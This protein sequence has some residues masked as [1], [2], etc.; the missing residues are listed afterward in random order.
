MIEAIIEA[1][2]DAKIDVTT[3]PMTEAITE[4]IIHSGKDMN[5]ATKKVNVRSSRHDVSTFSLLI[6]L[7]STP[8]SIMFPSTTSTQELQ[9]TLIELY[10]ARQHARPFGCQ[11]RSHDPFS[12]RVGTHKDDVPPS[13]SYPK[14]T[15]L[16]H[17]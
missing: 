5:I 3:D 12:E 15:C 13:L 2:V 1:M 8:A 4:A 17:R 10:K 14:D 11:S 16:Q 7:D 6:V 9:H